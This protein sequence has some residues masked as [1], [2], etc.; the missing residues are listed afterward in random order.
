MNIQEHTQKGSDRKIGLFKEGIS[1]D[2]V[3]SSKEVPLKIDA[4]KLKLS[5]SGNTKSPVKTLNTL[6]NQFRNLSF[7]SCRHIFLCSL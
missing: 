2:K 1:N 5:L 7:I 4:N 6:E 3:P